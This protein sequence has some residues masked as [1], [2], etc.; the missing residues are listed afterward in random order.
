MDRSLVRFVYL[1]VAAAS[2]VI[3]VLGIQ[4]SAYIINSILLAAI[5]TIAVL[6][7]PR[8]LIDRGWNPTLSLITTLL[9]VVVVLALILL[10][11]WISVGTCLLPWPACVGR[12]LAA[13]WV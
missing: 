1:L 10:L 2:V 4:S 5:I 3:I 13:P 8:R 9:M 12:R 6:P 7:I 11:A